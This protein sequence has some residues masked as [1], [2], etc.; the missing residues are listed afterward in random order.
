[1]L[2]AC[3]RVG[4]DVP[5]ALAR[6][7]APS[8]GLWNP[9]KPEQIDAWLTSLRGQSSQAMLAERS[10]LS[11]Q[12]V[13]RVLSGRSRGR[14]PLVLS[15]LHAMT[16]RMPDLIGQVV[17]IEKVPA[18]AREAE[19][20]RAL[21]RLAFA[22]PWSP[23][24]RSWLGTQGRVPVDEAP[25]LLASTLGLPVEAASELIDAL[26]SSGAA[27]IERKQLV[28]APRVTVEIDATAEDMRRVRSHWAR[29]SADR[30]AAGAAGDLFS[31]NVFAVGRRDLVRIREA[32]RRFYR[33]VRAIIAGSPPEV[34][35]MLVV[36]T[37]AWGE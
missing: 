25:G 34:P 7:H 4:I 20:R 12:Q 16:G 5:E 21:A 27:R 11:R 18:V 32:Q 30:I 3:G 10:G 1:M 31:F 17:P 22:H 37:A 28:P 6:F 13:G 2:R 35:A 15:L 14:L 9:E 19:A 26:V 29:V 24:A 23:A 33:E 36:H 8:A